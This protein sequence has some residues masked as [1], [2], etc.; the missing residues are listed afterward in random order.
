MLVVAMVVCSTAKVMNTFI[1]GMAIA[2]IGAGICEL[3]ALAAT[4][5]LAPTRKRGKYVAVL[6]LP[7]FPTAH[8]FSGV[9]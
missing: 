3:T 7:S 4:S 8:Q 5:E 9:N 1:G 6:V 2:G